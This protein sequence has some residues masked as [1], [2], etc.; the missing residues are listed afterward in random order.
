MAI[1]VVFVEVNVGLAEVVLFE[2][3]AAVFQVEEGLC[4]LRAPRRWSIAAATNVTA[5]KAI[6]TLNDL[7]V[8]KTVQECYFR[9]M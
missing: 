1:D 2:S 3:E 9:E 5:A 8:K 6:N 4:K 7:M